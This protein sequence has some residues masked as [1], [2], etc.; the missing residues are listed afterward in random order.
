MVGSTAELLFRAEAT[1]HDEAFTAGVLHNVGRLALDQFVLAGFAE[2]VYWAREHHMTLQDAERAV[3]GYTDAELGGALTEFWSF[4]A[5]LVD[6]VRNHALDV[7]ALPDPGSLMASVV[8][9]R[10]FVRSYGIPDGREPYQQPAEWSVPPLSVA[11]SLGRG[12]EGLF[13]RV[14]AFMDSSVPS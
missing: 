8:R 11:L 3:L 6:A 2:A 9:A 4:P 7:Y 12:I 13:S 5:P 14:D 10:L 1:G